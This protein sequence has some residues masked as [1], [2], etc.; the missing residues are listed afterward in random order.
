[1]PVRARAT[2]FTARVSQWPLHAFS[3]AGSARKNSLEERENIG[4]VSPGISARILFPNYLSLLPGW[5][6]Y[7]WYWFI[8]VTV[9]QQAH[10]LLDKAME[11]RI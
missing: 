11:Q 8:S 10:A 1:M 2:T 9:H 4:L 5:A 3:I 7:D 6:I